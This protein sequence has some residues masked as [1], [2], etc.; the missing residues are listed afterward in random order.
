MLAADVVKDYT[1]TV[2]LPGHTPAGEVAARLAPLAERGLREVQ[3]EGVPAGEIQVERMLDMRYQGQSYEL[4]LPFSEDFPADFHSLHQRT[5]GYE[6]PEAPV[7]IV[8]LRLRATG[9][10]S[11]PVLPT[12]PTAGPDP[13]LAFME[14]RPAVVDP[15]G[16][17]SE[18][19]FYRGEALRPGNRLAGPAIILRLDTTILLGPTDQAS[20]DTFGNFL[21]TI[22]Q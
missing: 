13:A 18:I 11:P 2:M 7:E 9:R 21:V 17:P 22:G 3:A 12:L 8:N 1:Q 14:R 15:H 20:I 10:V 5:Y 16:R 6:R 19:P 4:T